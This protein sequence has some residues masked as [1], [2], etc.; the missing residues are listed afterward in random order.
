[1]HLTNPVKATL[2]AT[3]ATL[4]CVVCVGCSEYYPN[5]QV[6]ATQGWVERSVAPGETVAITLRWQEGCND[7]PEVQLLKGSTRTRICRHAD[8]SVDAVCD[9]SLI[10]ISEP[11]RPY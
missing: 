2:L 7:G 1:M 9:L 3:L 8:F 6:S 4:A 11:T 10:H 5:L